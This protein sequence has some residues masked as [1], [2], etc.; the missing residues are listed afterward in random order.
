MSLM[1]SGDVRESWSLWIHWTWTPE[2]FWSTS[3]ACFSWMQWISSHWWVFPLLLL[4][5]AP[6]LKK[7]HFLHCFFVLS[8]V[9]W[10]ALPPAAFKCLISYEHL[11]SL[12]SWEIRFSTLDKNQKGVVVRELWSFTLTFICL[13][14]LLC[15][16]LFLDIPALTCYYY[17]FL[18][19]F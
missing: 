8:W 6:F 1:L 9:F 13:F 14:I 19:D 11:W 12:K 18:F 10:A 4:T 5:L 15:C 7:K 3:M 16:L 17:L 2:S